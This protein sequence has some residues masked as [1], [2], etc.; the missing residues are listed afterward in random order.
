[1]TMLRRSGVMLVLFLTCAAVVPAQV[2]I[3]VIVGEPTGLSVRYEASRASSFDGALAWSFLG[4]GSIYIHGDYLLF[5]DLFSVPEGRL[6]LYAGIGAKLY[7]G[8]DVGVGARIPLGALYQFAS[9]PLEIFLE[10]AP[11]LL[12]FPSTAPDAGGGLGIRFRL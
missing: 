3:G 11:G 4:T 5:F 1:M 2:G 12:L 6:P 10:I 7:I 8:S 9:V